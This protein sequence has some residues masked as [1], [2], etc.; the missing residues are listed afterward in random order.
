MVSRQG[1]IKEINFSVIIALIVLFFAV[2]MCFNTPG[3]VPP[4]RTHQN[5]SYISLNTN[6]AVPSIEIRIQVFQK[7]W[8]LNKDNFNLLAFSR[9][10][11]F[12]N[13]MTGLTI[14]RYQTFR[15]SYHEIPFFL[16]RYH[17][18]PSESDDPNVL[19]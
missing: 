19:S 14:F 3:R 2:M 16:L 17:L 4:L 7:T 1:N 10:P 12:A 18:F 8:I 5:S 11:V 15:Q 6:N 13:K 9:S